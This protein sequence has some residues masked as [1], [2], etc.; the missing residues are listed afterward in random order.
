MMH[1]EVC[2]LS[3]H[4]VPPCGRLVASRASSSSRTFGC[5]PT[6]SYAMSCLSLN[7]AHFRKKKQGK[8]NEGERRAVSAVCRARA[9]FRPTRCAWAVYYCHC[10]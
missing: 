6:V 7:N 8:K 1:V 4:G 3:A 5:V 10:W 2:S 9:C